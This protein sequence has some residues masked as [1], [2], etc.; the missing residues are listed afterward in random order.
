MKRLSGRQITVLIAF[1]AVFAVAPLSAQSQ[2]G[3]ARASVRGVGA[4]LPSGTTSNLNDTTGE[5]PTEHC[6]DIDPSEPC[7][8]NGGDTDACKTAYNR[9]TC[10]EGCDCDYAKNMKTCGSSVV[11][12]REATQKKYKCYT[13][14]TEDYGS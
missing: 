1:A 8:A 9:E 7:Y 12:K 13:D 14:C 4:G 2:A 3:Y 11:C 6:G 5:S 10:L